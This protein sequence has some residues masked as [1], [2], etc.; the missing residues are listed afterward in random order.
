LSDINTT[1][2]N[3][4]ANYSRSP[5]KE[6]IEKIATPA[7]MQL[8]LKIKSPS[9]NKDPSK[10]ISPQKELGTLKTSTNKLPPLQLNKTV[11][12]LSLIK[13]KSPTDDPM[14]QIL[15]TKAKK[16]GIE[17]EAGD[18]ADADISD[19]DPE[20]PNSGRDN[21]VKKY[22]KKTP[23]VKTPKSKTTPRTK[24]STPKSIE[25]T[26]N[27]S[28]D[29]DSNKNKIKTKNK[30]GNGSDHGDKKANLLFPTVFDSDFDSDLE[31]PLYP[32]IEPSKPPTSHTRRKKSNTQTT[33]ENNVLEPTNKTKDI[34][35]KD[36]TPDSK[37]P[38]L[39]LLKKSLHR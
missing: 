13:D 30:S 2:K 26:E 37:H 9:V 22:R 6:Q 24:P 7:L 39:D 12:T 3:L 38:K 15:R 8:K 14:N 27:S 16:Y 17:L 33:I 10:S 21:K 4:L 29:S 1:C 31:E 28:S 35:V 32:N 5:T 19:D 36:S 23:R 18:K 34:S 25:K 11:D 20:Q